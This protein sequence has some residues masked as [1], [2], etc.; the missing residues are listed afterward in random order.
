MQCIRKPVALQ[1]RGHRTW[2]GQRVKGK[3]SNCSNIQYNSFMRSAAQ[4]LDGWAMHAVH[5][6]DVCA[7]PTMDLGATQF[8]RH[9]TPSLLPTPCSE[10]PNLQGNLVQ[11]IWF[12]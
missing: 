2:F 5:H 10:I 8:L 6:D 4:E 3:K 7:W 12:L 11:H 9:G 1:Y